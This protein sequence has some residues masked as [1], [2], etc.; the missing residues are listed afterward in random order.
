VDA[1]AAADEVTCTSNSSSELDLLSPGALITAAA[2]GGGQANKSGT[3]MATAHASAVAALMMQAQPGLTPPQIESI[4]KETGVPVTDA[5]NGRVTPRIDAY[6]AVLRVWGSGSAPPSAAALSGTV[7]LQGRPDHSGTTIS[8]SEQ[9]CYP[10]A[11]ANATSSVAATDAQGRF[12]VGAG[13]GQLFQCLQAT[14]PG[15][16]TAQRDSPIGDLGTI[17]LPGGDVVGD[18]V[19]NIFDMAFIA[20]RYGSNDPAGDLNGDGRVDV[21]DLVIAAGNY[22][23]RSPV[24]DWR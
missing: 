2:L 24:T 10:G 22:E 16:L 17:T 5:R 9:P 8:L 19:V 23:R 13:A 11:S 6:A 4:L 1:N 12:E 15:F 7:L 18:G 20:S 21:F 3:S 14:H